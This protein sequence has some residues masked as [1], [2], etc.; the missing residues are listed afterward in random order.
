MYEKRMAT[1]SAINN[2]PVSGASAAKV[3]CVAITGSGFSYLKNS[4]TPGKAK[5]ASVWVSRRRVT[6]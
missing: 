3:V 4:T 1:L 2:E 6:A 5:P